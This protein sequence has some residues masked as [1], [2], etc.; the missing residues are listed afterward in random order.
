M[1]TDLN[2]LITESSDTK[3]IN[4]SQKILEVAMFSDATFVE[5]CQKIGKNLISVVEKFAE[6]IAE[7]KG[8]KIDLSTVK[9]HFLN[10]EQV[11]K[12]FFES[13]YTGSHALMNE[14]RT[15]L[16]EKYKDQPDVKLDSI[17][18]LMEA[19]LKENLA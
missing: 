15:K 13:Q 6:K 4:F 8:V 7:N 16:R 17:Q 14:F 3:E 2:T 19:M 18:D 9:Y 11:V 5:L 12:S 1:V 10:R